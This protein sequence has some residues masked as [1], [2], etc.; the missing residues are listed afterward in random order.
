MIR[1]LIVSSSGAFLRGLHGGPLSW[2]LAP[3]EPMRM[4]DSWL[5]F[6]KALRML[7]HARLTLNDP[8]LQICKV[9]VAATAHGWEP[10][11]QETVPD[12]FLP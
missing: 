4:G 2:A 12:P 7:A 3:H 8:S 10:V 5:D 9:T 6:S 11:R 1:Y